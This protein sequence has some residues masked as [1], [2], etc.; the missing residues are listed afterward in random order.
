MVY[1]NDQVFD[2]ATQFTTLS[3][4]IPD[5]ERILQILDRQFL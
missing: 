2:R 1:Y 5:L 4:S 3:L